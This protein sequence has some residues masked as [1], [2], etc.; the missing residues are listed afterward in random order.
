MLVS[1][2]AN[3]SPMFILQNPLVMSR[4]GCF[5]HALQPDRESSEHHR[6]LGFSS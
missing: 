1:Y 2:A 3:M 6:S 4:Y 5:G